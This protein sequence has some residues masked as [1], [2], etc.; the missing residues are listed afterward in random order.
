M[1]IETGDANRII[2][3][4]HSLENSIIKNLAPSGA[5]NTQTLT[6]DTGSKALWVGVYI[7]SICCAVVMTIAIMARGDQVDQARRLDLANDKLS[8]I[9]QWSPELAKKV[10]QAVSDKH[11]Q[12][13]SP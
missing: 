10:D 1:A 11:P 2:E 4:F 9:L 7:S 5:S 3:A 13:K 8:V 12:E 6:L